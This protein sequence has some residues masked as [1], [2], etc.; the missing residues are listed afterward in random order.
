MCTARILEPIEANSTEN[1]FKVTAGLIAALPLVVE[2]ENLQQNQM[3]NL[4]IK[5][6]Y[7][8]QNTYMVVPRLRDLKKVILENGKVSEDKMKLRTQVLLSHGVWTEASQVEISLCLS[9][10]RPGNELELCKPVKVTL[11]PKPVKRGI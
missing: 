6:K 11:F 4:R 2:I 5:I 1:V 3:Q 8:D 7:P 10:R 9:V